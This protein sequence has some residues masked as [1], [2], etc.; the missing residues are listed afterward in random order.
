MEKKSFGKREWLFLIVV[1]ALGQLIVH[2]VSW[3]Y[4]ANAN[5]LGYVS[6][7]GTI[8]SIILAVIAI[9]YGFVQTVEQSRSSS[10]IASQITSLYGVVETF[11]KSGGVLSE[12]LQQLGSIS[13]GIVKSV[14]L[15]EKSQE[16]I[17]KVQSSVD[18][19]R[20]LVA[21]A[22]GGLSTDGDRKKKSETV[23]AKESRLLEKE[24]IDEYLNGFQTIPGIA[25]FAIMVANKRG[26]QKLNTIANKFFVDVY[27]EVVHPDGKMSSEIA[28]FL[29]GFFFGAVRALYPY[30]SGDADATVRAPFAE[31]IRRVVPKAKLEGEWA[32]IRDRLVELDREGPLPVAP[33]APPSSPA[34]A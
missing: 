5:A 15:S 11:Q 21:K 13:A 32:K 3:R 22:G 4:A 30:I 8:V 29:E 34:A 33:A 27:R 10:T 1:L 26:E 24:V 9:I 25:V 31:G 6:F 19:M 14:A 16:Q 20:D 12:Q 18:E 2:M 7:A 28:L 17:I 23:P